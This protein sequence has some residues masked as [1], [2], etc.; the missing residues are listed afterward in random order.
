M[1]V[2]ESKWELC[3]CLYFMCT[4][5]QFLLPMPSG[6]GRKSGAISVCQDK[7]VFYVKSVCEREGIRRTQVYKVPRWALPFHVKKQALKKLWIKVFFRN[8]YTHTPTV[9]HIGIQWLFP[10]AC[11]TGSLSTLCL[12]SSH[13][14]GQG[15]QLLAPFTRDSSL[16]VLSFS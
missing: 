6:I 3:L 12:E 10:S 7:G 5:F 14:S 4:V 13:T 15:P 16:E 2:R 8:I 11:E 1:P 9:K